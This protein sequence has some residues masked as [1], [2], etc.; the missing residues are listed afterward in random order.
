M[1]ILSAFSNWPQKTIAIEQET[2][3]VVDGKPTTTWTTVTGLSAVPCWVYRTGDS[4]TFIDDKFK[5]ISG[6]EIIIDPVSLGG[7]AIKN[8]MRCAIDGTY[9]YLREP[10]NVSF[11]NELV[12]IAADGEP[13]AK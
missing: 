12:V 8:S 3:T 11:F 7:V 9:W 4:R 13:H 1:G 2:V 6:I 10:D 5:N